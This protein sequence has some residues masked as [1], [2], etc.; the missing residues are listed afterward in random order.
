MENTV[1]LLARRGQILEKTTGGSLD[2]SPGLGTAHTNGSSALSQLLLIWVQ[3]WPIYTSTVPS[4]RIKSLAAVG[5][6]H[7]GEKAAEVANEC[8]CTITRND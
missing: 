3:F 8:D 7:K 6:T 4:L 5:V 2:L 1:V